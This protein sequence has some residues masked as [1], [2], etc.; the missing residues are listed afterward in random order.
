MK[1]CATR[2]YEPRPRNE[3]ALRPPDKV[4]RARAVYSST[5]GRNTK[6][7][8]PNTGPVS[9]RTASAAGRASLGFKVW[10][11]SH[12]WQRHLEQTLEPLNLTHLQ[13]VLLVATSYLASGGSPPTQ[14]RVAEFT[15][16][17]RMMVSKILSLL[18]KK[19]YIERRPHP[20]I[21]RANEVLLTKVG[22]QIIKKAMPLW[23]K[24][25]NA[26]FGRLGAMRRVDFTSLLD[27]LMEP[28]TRV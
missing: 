2:R 16:F 21:A 23:K 12:G 25:N 27:E 9:E 3:G 15:G 28:L 6:E 22:R 7:D 18:E 10:S 26:Y 13:F 11:I 24:A 14:G 5:M 19:C 20:T 1:R 4:E 17:D 8:A